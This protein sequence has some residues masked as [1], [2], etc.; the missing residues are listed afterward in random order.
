MRFII[1]CLC[2]SLSLFVSLLSAHCLVSIQNQQPN[3]ETAITVA[4]VAQQ[5]RGRMDIEWAEKIQINENYDIGF[6][7]SDIAMVFTR[8]EKQDVRLKFMAF[9]IY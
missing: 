1:L 2:L 7:V 4:S 6:G 3:N 9:N 8:I 5:Y